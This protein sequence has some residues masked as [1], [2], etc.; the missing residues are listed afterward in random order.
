MRVLMVAPEFPPDVGGMQV[1][2]GETAARLAARGHDVLVLTD[3]ANRSRQEE[4]P[5][6]VRPVLGRNPRTVTVSIREAARR[7]ASEVILL[8][9]AG[10]APFVTG[11]RAHLPPVVVRTAGND[12]YGAWHGPRL[13]LRFLFWRL[14]HRRPGSLGSILRRLDQERRAAAVLSALSRCDRVLCNSSY[15]LARLRDLGV[16]GTR[17]HL[18]VGGVDTDLFRPAAPSERQE[19]RPNGAAMLGIAGHL[20]PVKGIDVALRMLMLM[21]TAARSAVLRVAGSGPEDRRLQGLARSL[22]VAERVEFL[23]NLSPAGMVRFYRGLDLYLQPS[24]E[25]RH[26]SSGIVQ[27]ETMGRAIC[28][29]AA[30]GVPVVA[31]RT[32]GISDVVEDGITGRLVPSGDPNALAAV[33]G[34]LLDSP[35]ECRRLGDAGRRAAVD[36]FSWSSI[37]RETERHLEEAR[38]K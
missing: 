1:H 31:S 12:A 2:A 38:K 34:A 10:F 26:E 18:M 36:R 14:P 21:A 35:G 29:A 17:L 16:P 32:G 4:I 9:N 8:M 23:G 11:P 37:V 27:V 15:V 6:A 7:Q 13:P 19:P 25:I 3:A 33:V 24:V 5:I 30:C 22:N 28:E 20:L